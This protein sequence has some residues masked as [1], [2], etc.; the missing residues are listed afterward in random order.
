MDF[1]FSAAQEEMRATVRR[2]FAARAPLSYVRA[3]IDSP[4]G[5]TDDVWRGLAGLGAGGLLAPERVGGT[6]LSMVDLGVVLEEAGRALY[7]GP[8]LSSA[9]GA[10]S[11]AVALGADELVA[12]L[13][14]GER[15]G[16]VARLEPGRR[17]D[18][19]APGTTASGAG[20]LRGHKL[21]IADGATA[22]L[23]LVAATGP[24]G[25]GVYALDRDAPGLVIEPT[26]TVDGTR[27]TA[28]ARFEDAPARR[29]ASGPEALAAT[30]ATADLL[31][32]GAAVDGV[33][34]AACALDQAVEYAKVR[35]QFDRPI[36]SFQAVQ[37][38]C[39][40]MLRAVELSRA[41]AYYALW[42]A[43]ADV[44]ERHRA[45]TMVSAYAGEWLPWVGASVI[46]VFGG[47]G[48]TWEHDAHLYYKRLLSL[49]HALGGGP[50]EQLEE[51]ARLVLGPATSTRLQPR[52]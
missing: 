47:V 27:P 36:G 50:A 44:A 15:T 37:H 45:A 3:V 26:P 5:A 32:I 16:T 12:P 2:Y 17:Y 6:G 13:V 4:L 49:P 10:V 43:A 23:L 33:G 31:A 11:L 25:F 39:A 41:G 7:P 52:G 24:S 40:D 51:L 21:H 30:A 18:W 20:R 28:S 22:D 29:L 8:L 14:S 46:Q 9:V 1:E 34:A 42:A 38:L 35:H 19:R 48:F